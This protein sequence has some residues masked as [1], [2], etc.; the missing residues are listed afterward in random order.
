MIFSGIEISR[1]YTLVVPSFDFKTAEENK[2]HLYLIIKIYPSGTLTPSLSDVKI[3]KYPT[4]NTA[5]AKSCAVLLRSVG[6]DDDGGIEDGSNDNDGL[7][8]PY[9]YRR[10]MSS[11]WI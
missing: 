1:P 5:H 2:R 11:D 3:G 10:S 7:L 6:D 9:L 4:T 8:F